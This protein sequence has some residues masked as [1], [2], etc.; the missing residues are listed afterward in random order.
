MSRII[1]KP[2][3]AP[4][5][6]AIIIDSS[7]VSV[8]DGSVQPFTQKPKPKEFVY[9]PPKDSGEPPA[10]HPMLKPSLCLGQFR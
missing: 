2:F 9:I 8:P 6:P 4:L 10:Y 3:E 5:A 1:S 7:V